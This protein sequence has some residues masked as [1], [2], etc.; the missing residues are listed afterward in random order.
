MRFSTL[1]ACTVSMVLISA[2]LA[3][4]HEEPPLQR[5]EPTKNSSANY[6]QLRALNRVLVDNEEAMNLAS[7]AQ[8][9]REVSGKA[10]SLAQALKEAGCVPDQHNRDRGDDFA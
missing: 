8:V 1:R 6:E 4:N 5:R 10:I 2:V 9:N 7:A 3:C